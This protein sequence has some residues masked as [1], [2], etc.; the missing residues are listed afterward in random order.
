MVGFQLGLGALFGA[1]VE[2]GAADNKDMTAVAGGYDAIGYTIYSSDTAHTKKGVVKISFS[3]AQ[4]T[5]GS[6]TALQPNFGAAMDNFDVSSGRVISM[7][8]LV[9]NHSDD[10]NKGGDLCIGRVPHNFNPFGDLPSQMEG[11]PKNRG[12][13]LPLATGG[14]AW[15]TPNQLDEFSVDDLAASAAKYSQSE[16]LVFGVPSMSA[17][18]RLVLHFAWRVEFYTK[19]QAFEKLTTPPMLDEF[20]IFQ[21]ALLLLPAYSC[22]P[23]HKDLLGKFADMAKG[24]VNAGQKVFNHYQAHKDLYDAALQGFLSML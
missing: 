23:D 24:A 15:W 5:L 21:H 14:Y 9:A 1:N 10:L 13:T 3:N 18:A 17:S 6:A 22:N 4:T 8:V 7:A 12:A 16:Y 11:L 19:N 20:R 2:R